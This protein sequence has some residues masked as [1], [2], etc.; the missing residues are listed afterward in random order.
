MRSS[1]RS[2]TFGLAG[3]LSAGAM[4]QYPYT[5][6]LSGTV[7]NCYPGQT[8][9]VQTV[10]GTM[11]QQ[12]FTLTLDSNTCSYS[13]FVSV[14]N[15]PAWLEVTTLCGGMMQVGS[16]SS[17]F[18]FVGDT[19]TSFIDL[20][21]GGGAYDCLQV[22]NGPDLPGTP[23][24]DG[25]PM[26][27]GDLWTPA[28]VCIGMD[29]TN[30][31]D[32]LGVPFGPNMPGTYCINFFGDTGVWSVDC[33]CETNTNTDPDCLGNPGGGALPGTP[34]F[35]LNQPGTWSADCICVLDST[36]GIPIASA[37]WMAR[38]CPAQSA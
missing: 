32:C 25:N 14:S 28:C 37:S 20:I 12:S 6:A 13:V 3:L 17:Q 18:D 19:A 29:T 1:L 15:Q 7:A 33:I 30:T 22:L 10:Q 2:L 35:V 4:A 16:D 34:C 36:V 5:I 26:T 27:W 8:V 31:T 11:P 23:C 9:T 24:D 38:T 21:C